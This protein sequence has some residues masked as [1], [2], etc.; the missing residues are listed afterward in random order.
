M[1]ADD[2]AALAIENLR[3]L[4]NY[5]FR[6]TRDREGAEDLVQET[7]E[8]TFL[9]RDRFAGKPAVRPMMFRI[10]HNLFVNQYR[11]RRRRPVIVSL[12]AWEDRGE[13]S[14]RLPKESPL[15]V[16]IRN[17][18]SDEVEAALGDLKDVWRETLW[19]R[20]VEGYSY[21]EIAEITD[22]PIGTVRS[23]VARSRRALAQK[24]QD[25]ARDRGIGSDA[26]EEGRQ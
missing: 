20:A 6:L 2:L 7:F 25:Y 24:L 22:V 8:R 14:Q 3:A 5:A 12:E 17:A 10:L 9:N 1:R 13:T 26:V 23:R 11:S 21:Q 15:E 4:F 18:L 16:T 19:L